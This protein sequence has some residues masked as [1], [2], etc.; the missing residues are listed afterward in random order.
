MDVHEKPVESVDPAL[1]GAH[2]C[3][4]WDDLDLEQRLEL[5]LSNPQLSA[6]S[7]PE[8]LDVLA[9]FRRLPAVWLR[10][11]SQFKDYRGD[12]FALQK[13]VDAILKAEKAARAAPADTSPPEAPA[14]LFAS[15]PTLKLSPKKEPRAL[16]FNLMEVLTHDPAWAGVLRYNDF[17]GVVELHA[18]PPPFTLEVAWKMRPLE[19]HHASEIARWFQDVWDI[20]TTT[21]LVQEALVT[22]AHRSTYNPV[23]DYLTGLTW[24]GIPRLDTW[25]STYCHVDDS[26]YVRAVGAKTLI[27]GAARIMRPGC[28]LDTMTILAGE[29]G[30]MKST[31]WEILASP[32]WFTDHLSDLHTKDAPMDLRSKWIVEF[33]DLDTFGRSETE[34]IKRFLSASQ[35]HYRA[36]YSRHASTIPRAVIFVGTTNKATFLKDE[37]GNRRFWPVHVPQRCDLAALARDRDQLWAE[38][39]HRFLAGEIWYL[40]GDVLREAEEEQA[41]R[42]EVDPWT[43]P[44]LAYVNGNLLTMVKY[45]GTRVPS[46]TTNELLELALGLD[47]LH[48]TSGNSR[49]VAAI[50]RLHEWHYEKVENPDPTSKARQVKVFIRK[51][52]ETDTAVSQ[53]SSVSSSPPLQ[54]SRETDETDETDS[55][56]ISMST[57]VQRVVGVECIEVRRELSVSAVSSVST[58]AIPFISIDCTEADAGAASAFVGLTPPVCRSQTPPATCLTCA[59]KTTWIIRGNDFVCYRCETVAPRREG[60]I[61]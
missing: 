46:I 58:S 53:K 18:P 24:D 50:L 3:L 19:E 28:K 22:V 32:P 38:A 40:T 37:T 31:V 2:A 27:A 39:L 56:G 29:Q 45:K 26:P 25:L 52:D 34:T 44:I 14:R 16:L 13:A 55:R 60:D 9:Y 49:R 41:A 59:R 35:D 21:A 8:A 30:F 7:T 4:T 10:I 47:K 43:A 6:W 15:L 48:W 36:P 61:L 57:E 54:T 20:C 12:A 5:I 11:V 33:A 17:S 23:R 51:A 1:T 42:V